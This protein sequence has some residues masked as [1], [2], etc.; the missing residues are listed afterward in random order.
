MLIHH[1]YSKNVA[2]QSWHIKLP[3]SINKNFN[4]GLT[5]IFKNRFLL[6]TDFY[7]LNTCWLTGADTAFQRG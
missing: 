3:L 7:T 4:K 6:S 1:T 5:T 2:P